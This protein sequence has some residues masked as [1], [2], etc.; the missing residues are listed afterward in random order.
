MDKGRKMSI[1][2]K[3]NWQ[4]EAND[5]FSGRKWKRGQPA[6]YTVVKSGNRQVYFKWSQWFIGG[7]TYFW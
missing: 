4:R 7:V 3:N 5:T 1:F 6:A 2:I